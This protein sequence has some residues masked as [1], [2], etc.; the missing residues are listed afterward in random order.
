MIGA[1]HIET[2]T[3]NIINLMIINPHNGSILQQQAVNIESG[4]LPDF[5]LEYNEDLDMYLAHYAFW[6]VPEYMTTGI[7]VFDDDLTFSP[8]QAH[9]NRNQ[10]GPQLHVEI[11]YY[12]DTY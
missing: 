11:L 12:D 4:S 10:K 6:L 8:V 3:D 5:E 1:Q 2:K 7:L 9:L